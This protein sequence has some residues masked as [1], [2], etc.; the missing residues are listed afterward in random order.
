MNRERNEQA[1]LDRILAQMA[2]ETP[3]MPADFHNRWTAAVRAEAANQQK[4]AGRRESPRQWRYILSAAAVFVFLIGG[5]L[6]T[7]S[8]D[9]DKRIN[10]TP[11]AETGAEQ[12]QQ[13]EAAGAAANAWVPAETR[14]PA[15]TSEPEAAM[16]DN[17]SFRDAETAEEPDMYMA[18]EAAEEAEWDAAAPAAAEQA[19]ET[20]AAKSASADY[21][22]AGGA[23]YRD[24]E[25]GLYMSAEESAAEPETEDAG[26]TAGAAADETAGEET[27][28]EAAAPEPAEKAAE[29][30]EF[31][32]FLKDL[33]IFT[34]KALAVAAAAAALAFG[35]AAVHKAWK[36]KKQNR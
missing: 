19:F 18:M 23:A 10:S 16:A 32:S 24:A 29:E 9:R 30:S 11:A 27:E 4:T 7:R 12:K 2:Q 20:N 22:A 31:V 3:D 14:E 1:E 17:A 5:T 36:K 34:L 35:T 28:E 15:A 8:M 13:T 26:E 25:A 33:G 6:L 21:A